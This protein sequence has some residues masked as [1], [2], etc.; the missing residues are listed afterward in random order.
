MPIYL[1]TLG[2]IC[3]HNPQALSK[4]LIQ[5][6]QS[7][8]VLPKLQGNLLLRVLLVS[9]VRLCLLYGRVSC[10]V[11][12]L[13]RLYLQYGCVSCTIVLLQTDPYQQAHT[14]HQTTVLQ[15]YLCI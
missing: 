8:V 13:A 3:I 9:L 2:E 11:V 4:Q 14:P 10:T 1:I 12:S 15:K 7:M 5:I 6:V